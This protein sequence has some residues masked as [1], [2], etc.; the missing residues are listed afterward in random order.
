MSPPERSWCWQPDAGPLSSQMP[1][2]ARS[3]TSLAKIRVQPH[4]LDPHRPVPVQVELAVRTVGS[5]PCRGEERTPYVVV[6]VQPDQRGPESVRTQGV[7][8][9]LHQPG[10]VTLPGVP[11]VDRELADLTLGD[12]VGVG[13]ARR[14]GDREPADGV[15]LERDQHPVS[16]VLGVVQR[17][18]P[19]R[20]E[21]AGL[22]RVEHLGRQHGGV[23]LPP[24]ADLDRGDARGVVGPADPDGHV[25][26]GSLVVAYAAILPAAGDVT[27]GP[28]H[29]AHCVTTVVGWR[30]C[31]ATT[32]PHRTPRTRPRTPAGRPGR[33]QG[34]TWTSSQGSRTSGGSSGRTG[35]SS[36][37]TSCPTTT[38]P[39]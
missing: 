1:E 32:S 22:E 11:G 5:P 24:G 27:Q 15:A 4:L 3:Q 20:G 26:G 39:R 23:L 36:R 12:R 13:I 9:G 30:V 38:A 37:A 7:G 34:R 17:G 28:P 8:A 14:A 35:G 25:G 21:L 16:G 10:A 31:T 29:G 33:R 18:L 2:W 19:G 6:R